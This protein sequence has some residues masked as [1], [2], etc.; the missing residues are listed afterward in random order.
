MLGI[1][2]SIVTGLCASLVVAS[3]LLV[4]AQGNPPAPVGEWRYY[5]GDKGFTRYSPLDQIN[6][7]N[8][9]NVKILWRRPKVDAQ[10]ML[11]FPDLNV[12]DNL[13]ST[14]IMV[15]GVLYAPNGVGLVEA[16]DAGTGKT[17]WVQEPVEKTLEGMTGRSTRGG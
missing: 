15:G 7:E 14:P 6:R 13:R 10:L 5:G 17:I 1:Q 3:S 16:F 11:A 8:V 2:R 4:G 12:N 9:G